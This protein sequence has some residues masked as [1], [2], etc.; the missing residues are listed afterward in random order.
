MG[1]ALVA[2]Y[3]LSPFLSSLSYPMPAATY[4]RLS[5]PTPVLPRGSM[6][7]PL[8][9]VNAPSGTLLKDILALQPRPLV[10]NTFW[11]TG[12]RCRVQWEMWGGEWVL[13]GCM[14]LLAG[15]S[16]MLLPAYRN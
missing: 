15:L 11:T 7:R 4:P 10:E 3:N 8:S 6:P 13:F 12:C 2:G 14:Q 16:G 1:K 5:T 9:S